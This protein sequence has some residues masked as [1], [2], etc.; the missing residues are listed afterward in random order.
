MTKIVATDRQ[1]T[2]LRG[3]RRHHAWISQPS[4][5]S[6]TTA[7]ILMRAR[8]GHP[9]SLEAESSSSSSAS[10]RLC[11]E[12]RIVLTGSDLAIVPI[13]VV[14]RRQC[15]RCRL[16]LHRS[17]LTTQSTLSFSRISDNQEMMNMKC[18]WRAGSNGSHNIMMTSHNITI[19]S[20]TINY[21]SLQGGGRSEI[22]VI[23]AT[24]SSL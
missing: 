1:C 5:Q 19:R 6:L 8:E 21:A 7:S 10:S 2:I 22:N 14:G 17:L 24:I 12:Q 18:V 4:K 16:L 9:I 20:H 23:N 3:R 13:A 15:R 11:L